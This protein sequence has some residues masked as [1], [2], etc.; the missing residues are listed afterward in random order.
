MAR[1]NCKLIAVTAAMIA[2]TGPVHLLAA[3]GQLQLSVVDQQTRE[4]LACRLHLQNA[5][6]KPVKIPSDAKAGVV[7][8][9]DHVAFNGKLLL[10]LPVGNY[11]FFMERGLEYL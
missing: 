8:W 11:T 4:P 7:A 1:L 10:K 3:D 5:S 6:G 2:I 9:G